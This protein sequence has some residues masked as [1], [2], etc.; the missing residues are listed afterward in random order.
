MPVIKFV[1]ALTHLKVD[2][3]VS[4]TNGVEC[5]EYVSDALDRYPGAR[6]LTL[7][8]KHMVALRHLNEVFTGGIGGYGLVCMVIS[9]LQVNSWPL[10]KQTQGLAFL[11]LLY[12]SR[13][14]LKWQP[15]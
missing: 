7:I 5:A 3:I 4:S 8:A 15:V 2:I 14:T 1:E 9:F 6:K 10:Q 13:C 12:Q 11:T